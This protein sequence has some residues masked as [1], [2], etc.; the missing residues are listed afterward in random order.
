MSLELLEAFKY[1][2]KL[3]PRLTQQNVVLREGQR[4]HPEAIVCKLLDQTV[5]EG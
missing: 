4:S 5:P 3:S 1:R 2:E